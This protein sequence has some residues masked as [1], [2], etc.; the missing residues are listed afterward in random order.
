MM[1]G[2]LLLSRPLD[3]L[4]ALDKALCMASRTVMDGI[5]DSDKS[6]LVKVDYLLFIFVHYFTRL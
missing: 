3:T 2:E 4:A 6:D 5:D 1:L